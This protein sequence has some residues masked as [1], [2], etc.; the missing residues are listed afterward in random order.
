[1]N[2]ELHF[3]FKDQFGTVRGW[4]QHRAAALRSGSCDLLFGEVAEGSAHFSFSPDDS[5]PPQSQAQQW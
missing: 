4:G 5:S 3:I 2:L 1:M